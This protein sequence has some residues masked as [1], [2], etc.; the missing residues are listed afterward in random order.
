MTASGLGVATAGLIIRGIAGHPP[1]EHI[2]VFNLDSEDHQLYQVSEAPV[3]VQNGTWSQQDAPIGDPGVTKT[4]SV[5]VLRAIAAGNDYLKS[6][7]A[8]AKL[9]DTEP[10]H[11]GAPPDGQGPGVVLLCPVR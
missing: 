9:T 10:F 7:V 11:L 1:D 8:T 6:L 4:Q 5:V 3:P 2:W